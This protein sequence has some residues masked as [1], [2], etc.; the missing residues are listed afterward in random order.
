MRWLF[1]S[2]LV[3]IALWHQP[4]RA[5]ELVEKVPRLADARTEAVNT[6][7]RDG[8]IQAPDSEPGAHH[9]SHIPEPLVFDLVRGL[10][11]ERGE[12]EANSLFRVPVQQGEARLLWAPE[13]EWAF[14]DGAALEFELPIENT[15]IAAVKFAG[16]VRLFGGRRH[17]QG[18]QAIRED[19]VRH[20]GNY[21]SLLWLTGWHVL[22]RTCLMMM[23]GG[24]AFQERGD[25]SG[26]ALLN[27][28]VFQRLNRSRAVGLETNVAMG[29]RGTDVLLAPQVHVP[30]GRTFN[31]QFGLG[32]Q[33]AGGLWAPVGMGRLIVQR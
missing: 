21:S 33:R 25:V 32:A 16:Q 6:V 26:A 14:H 24:R 20:A 27:A 5:E 22:P 13:I 8:T 2:S 12:F 4:V 9:R 15:D 7:E 19:Y 30:V 10:D 31:I 29:Q 18:L 23:F 3:F 1:I 28:S 11:A 17:V